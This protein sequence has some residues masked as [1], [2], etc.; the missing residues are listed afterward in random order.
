MRGAETHRK[1]VFINAAFRVVRRPACCVL[2]QTNRPD[3]TIGAEI[4]PVERA[5][6][7]TDQIACFDFDAEHGSACRVNV[8]KTV[9]GNDES[10]FV[11]VVPVLAIKLRQHCIE[12][13]CG[14]TDVDHVGSYVTSALLQSLDLA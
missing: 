11:L 12:T 7:H 13:R 10:H 8:K 9:T 1:E 6:G 14:G 4:E 5:A 2:K 3:A